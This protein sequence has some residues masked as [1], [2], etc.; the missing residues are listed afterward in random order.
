MF[1]FIAHI[2]SET[3]ISKQP[4]RAINVLEDCINVRVTCGWHS[5]GWRLAD[6]P[7]EFFMG[8]YSLVVRNDVFQCFYYLGGFGVLKQR[9][10]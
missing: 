9:L 8:I 2:F 4:S 3:V 1:K 10:P 5:K 7:T 6:S